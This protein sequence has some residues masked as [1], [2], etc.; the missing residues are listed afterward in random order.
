MMVRVM[1]RVIMMLNVT[2]LFWSAVGNMLIVMVMVMVRVRV[3]VTLLLH[4][5]VCGR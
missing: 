4:T 3:N 1:V 2:L 5:L